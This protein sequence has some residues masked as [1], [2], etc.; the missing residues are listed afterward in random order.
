MDV[1]ASLSAQHPGLAARFV[2]MTG[3][4]VTERAR[5]ALA[6]TRCPVLTKPFERADVERVLC[7]LR[8][9]GA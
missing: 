3:G 8:A 5:Q 4:A 1:L 7:T 6:H 2:F 9:P